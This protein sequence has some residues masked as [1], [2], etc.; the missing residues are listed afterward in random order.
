MTKIDHY[1]YLQGE[2]MGFVANVVLTRYR[3][4]A[5]YLKALAKL[6]Q[7]GSR[8]EF[9]PYSMD[10]LLLNGRAVTWQ[11]VFNLAGVPLPP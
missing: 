10:H 6:A 9:A 11:Q 8:V 4:P 7:R 2:G 5:A 3:H 1:R